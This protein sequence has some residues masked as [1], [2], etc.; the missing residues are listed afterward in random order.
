MVMKGKILYVYRTRRKQ[1]LI[2]SQQ[3]RAPDSMLFGMNYLKKRG[4]QVDFFDWQYSL[5]NPFHWIC[6]WF[7]HLVI[8]QIGM[9][10]KL[11]QALSLL[12]MVHRY[13]AIVLTGDSAGLPFLWLKKIGLI[14]KPMIYL[15]SGL[16][17]ALFLH[18]KSWVKPFYKW[19]FEDVEIM[20][21]YAEVEREFFVREMG[22]PKE[23]IY[24][25]P[26]G[27]D[28][29]WFSRPSK[30]KRTIVAAAGI[31]SGRDYGTL[32][33]A[34]KDLS[35]RV[36][37]AC[38]PKNIL[39]LDVPTNVKVRLLAPYSTV[40][41]IFRRARVVVVPMKE[42]GRSA[43][44]MVVLESAS[45]KA[46]IIASA[47]RGITEAFELK[48]KQHLWYVPVENVTLLRRAIVYLWNHPGEGL[49]I[50]KAAS[51]LVKQRYASKHLAAN[52]AMFLDKLC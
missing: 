19:L 26:Y 24:Y 42:Q 45:A 12:P 9:G 43:G 20:T 33:A 52:I 10:F 30:L 40:R 2:D 4:Y 6:Y 51:K 31:D 36:E 18:P 7:E 34:V 37:V 35:F 32:F 44:Q 29:Q 28:W 50:G 23:K 5:I 1:I 49:K 8:N 46:P 41:N 21:C 38:H 14:R 15:S 13:D 48:N 17:G 22:V 25:I 3:G 39:N 11:D 27:T 47:V 16:T